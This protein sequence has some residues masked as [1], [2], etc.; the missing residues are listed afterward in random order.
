MTPPRRQLGL[1]VTAAIVI[2]NMIGTGVFT[3]TGFQAKDLHDPKTILLAW[4]IGGVIALCGAAAYAELGSMMPR[5]GG[6]YVYLREAYHPAVGFMS[7][8]VSLTAGFSAPIAVAALFFARYLGTVFPEL[9]AAAPW[10]T[11]DVGLFT[12]NV[13]LQHVIATGLIVA[14][15]CLHAF[16]TKIGGWVQ[17][18]FTA[19]KVLLIV[20]F[21]GG[22]LL[23]GTGDWSNLASQSG[24]FANVGTESFAI[25]LM[26]VSFA[27]SGWNAAAYIASDVSKP[28]KTLPRALLLGTGLVMVLYVLLNLVFLYA[29]PTGA[30]GGPPYCPDV[31]AATLA[32]LQKAGTCSNDFH[33]IY[34]VG[35]AAA[36]ALFGSRVGQLVSSVIALALVSAVSAMIMAGPR[37]YS[38]MAAD[39]ALPRKLAFHN[40]RGVPVT[41][42]VTQG[43]LACLFVFVGNPDT[44][45]RFV[46][47]TLA[48]FAGLT[49]AAVFVLRARGLRGAYRTFG[50]PV[51]PVLFIIV[52]AWIAY[53]QI[54][55]HPFESLIIGLVLALG[56]VVYWVTAR[57]QP[58]LPNEND[59][60]D[61]PPVPQVPTA[62][63]VEK[64]K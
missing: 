27:Y 8:W 32:Q 46:G 3:S 58:P 42:V 15:T 35:D 55:A 60:I 10:A 37:V 30:L 57:G 20:L 47:F 23:A 17:A 1:A 49:V 6:E 7:G 5:A 33:G 53:A 48:I 9:G 43:V 4:I 41:A 11:L 34:E 18:V 2:A 19:A 40:Q 45:I 28:E 12:I 16:D 13:G 63:V 51:T 14:I 56:A 22:G 21:I 44:L 61:T 64:D 50:Y 38:A 31:D 24:G 59:P 36:R 26:Y 62:R 54:R 29:V 52:S 39:R 25:A